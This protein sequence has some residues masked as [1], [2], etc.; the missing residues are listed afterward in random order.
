MR[1]AIQYVAAP[2]LGIFLCFA[3]LA[4]AAGPWLYDAYQRSTHI[5]NTREF[6]DLLGLTG[7]TV[8]PMIALAGWRFGQVLAPGPK[9]QQHWLPE[10]FWIAIS[11]TILVAATIDVTTIIW[12]GPE[13]A[14]VGSGLW[15]GDVGLTLGL[16]FIL[17]KKLNVGTLWWWSA[18]LTIILSTLFIFA[19]WRQPNTSFVSNALVGVPPGFIAGMALGL[20]VIAFAQSWEIFTKLVNS[21]IG[22][23]AAYL[24]VALIFAG[25]FAVLNAVGH[26]CVCHSEC[27]RE[28]TF[29]RGSSFDDGPPVFFLDE[30]DHLG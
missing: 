7:I 23:F 27:R 10:E 5:H 21:L 17:R 8:L 28:W 2:L 24:I 6:W 26:P 15:G 12:W 18:G 20:G 30:Y 16:G 29:S 19:L 22:F 11:A 4:V 14:N 13:S 3:T 25:F 1:L 9:R